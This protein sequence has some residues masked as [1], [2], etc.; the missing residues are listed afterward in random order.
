MFL[1][2][3]DQALTQES[4]NVTVFNLKTDAVLINYDIVMGKPLLFYNLSFIPSVPQRFFLLLTLAPQ[5]VLDV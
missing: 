4:F 5:W 3:K 2:T 1:I